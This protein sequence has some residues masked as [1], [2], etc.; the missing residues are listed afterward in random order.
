MKKL[1]SLL[2]LIMVVFLSCSKEEEP[3]IPP[4]LSD[5]NLIISFKLTINNEVLN[6]VIDQ[7]AKTIYFSVAGA[8]LNSLIPTVD[9]SDKARL[10]PSE[11]TPQNFSV[12]VPYTVYAENG[13]PNVYRVII[14]NR[15]LSTENKILS[16]SVN[17]NNETIEAVIDH[18]T[19][20]VSLDIGSIDKSA[21]IPTI[22]ISEYST[23]SPQGETAQNF[24]SPII[25]TVTAE[26]GTISEYTVIANMPEIPNYGASVHLYYIRASTMVSGKF[27]DP[28]KPGAEL[29]LFDGTNKYP[30]TIL[31]TESY[32]SQER[33]T[34]FNIFIK[35]P[36]NVPTYNNFKIV[37]KTNDLEVE[38][39]YLI[40]IVAENAP[41][42]ISLNQDSYYRDDI[43]IIA[44]ENLTDMISIPSNGSIFLIE[45]SNNYD[46]TVNPER[47]EVRLTLDYY[48]LFPS[49]FAR[50]PQEKNITFLGPERRVGESISAIFN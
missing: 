43:L 12:E 42:P 17:V 27:L 31:R 48:Y 44:G 37:Y 3:S 4:V 24:E 13:E 15:P 8:D 11:T 23:I 1:I 45:N 14:D 47:T 34:V 50:D 20:F 32:S 29:Y 28:D 7:T 30:L 19:K 36:E 18:D 25:Y 21:L 6:G 46:Y 41:R 33:I 38:S 16:F 39:E 2:S 10:S 26:N 22:S 40:D 49:Y 35:I 5:Q 9:Y